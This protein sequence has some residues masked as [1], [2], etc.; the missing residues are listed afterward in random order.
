MKLRLYEAFIRL[1]ELYRP[2]CVLAT[3]DIDEAWALGAR[4]VVIKDGKITLDIRPSEQKLPRVYGED[5]GLKKS[6]LQALIG[7]TQ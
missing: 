4:I 2:T 6:I 7:E 1:W 3:H 5:G